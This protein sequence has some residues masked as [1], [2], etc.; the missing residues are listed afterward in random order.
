[1]ILNKTEILERIKSGMISEY[2]DLDTQLQ[3]NGFDITIKEISL[4]MNTGTI[5]FNNTSR[6]LPL[7]LDVT[8]YFPYHLQHGAYLIEFNE[9]FNIPSDLTALGYSRSS[10]LRMGAFIPSAVWDAGFKGYG[11]GML[12]VEN[13]YGINIK[14]N[15]RVMQLVFMLRDDDKSAYDGMFNKDPPLLD[16]PPEVNVKSLNDI[17][18]TIE[19][20]HNK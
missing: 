20:L 5:D 1:M 12:L 15:A 7:Y 10:L 9:K 4:F 13:N 14:E 8:S 6:K 3:P 17:I 2:I 11:Q 16:D 19:N 18:D